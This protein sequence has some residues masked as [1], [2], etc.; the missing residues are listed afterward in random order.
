MAKL[1]GPKNSAP[2]LS[3]GGIRY[4]ADAAG[5]FE[6]PDEAVETLQRH[7]FKPVTEPEQ[8]RKK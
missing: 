8:K 5:V 2:S 1:K 7:G 3:F 4:E 6:V